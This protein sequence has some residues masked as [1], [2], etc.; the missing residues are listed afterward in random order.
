MFDLDTILLNALHEDVGS[1]DITTESC[2][3]P[4]LTVHGQIVAK[5]RTVLC[6]VELIGRV[7]SLLDKD[8]NVSI[9]FQDGSVLEPGTVIA[10]TE[11]PARAILTGERVVL[12]LL[13]RLS[14]IA[15]RTRNAVKEVEGTR[16]KICDTR[17]TTPG[18]RRLEKYAVRT[19]G[20]INHRMGLS[21]GILIK[22]N[23]IRA[24]GGI[25]QAVKAVR[26]Y[27]PHTLKIEIEAGT[28]EEVREA[29]EAGADIIMLDNMDIE[30]MRESVEWIAW[31]AKTEASGN[32]GI[33]SLVE[34][35]RTGVDYISVG[36][37]THSL[38]S[39]DISMNILP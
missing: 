2:I 4:E 31:R 7:F 38:C 27:A 22:D 11:G 21:D 33:K 19:G 17:K 3:P 36:A 39:A 13:Q 34:V 6:G 1:G 29:L 26:E 28:M 20:G 14:G 37:L 8:V 18:L 24:A 30:Q 25:P 16:A 5:S 10:R 32:M 9:R 12:N 23:H 15:E 35:A